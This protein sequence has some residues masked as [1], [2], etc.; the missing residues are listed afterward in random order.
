MQSSGPSRTEPLCFWAG[1]VPLH[2]I[3]CPIC[4]LNTPAAMRK[5]T[6]FALLVLGVAAVRAGCPFGFSG[7]A[8]DADGGVKATGRR[9]QQVCVPSPLG[10][11]GAARQGCPANSRNSAL[12]PLDKPTRPASACAAIPPF[13]GRRRRCRCRHPRPLASAS[14][15]PLVSQ[16]GCNINTLAQ[17]AVTNPFVPPNPVQGQVSMQG[18]QRRGMNACWMAVTSPGPACCSPCN[19][20]ELASEPLPVQPPCPPLPSGGQVH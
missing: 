3:P 13:A 1:Q 18:R 14:L 16:A 15:S 2:C 12:Q 5:F 20:A 8:E 7:G 6:F 10:R 11:T 19:P 17:Q 4:T 9:L